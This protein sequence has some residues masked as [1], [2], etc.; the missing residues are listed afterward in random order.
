MSG[1]EG[2]LSTIEIQVR[3]FFGAYGIRTRLTAM[4]LPYHAK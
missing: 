3:V 1:L 4:R 2:L